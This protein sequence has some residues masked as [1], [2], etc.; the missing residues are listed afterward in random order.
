MHITSLGQDFFKFDA[1]SHQLKGERTG[2]R[3]RLG[4][5]VNVVVAGVNLDEK[6]IDFELLGLQSKKTQHPSFEPAKKSA[7]KDKKYKKDHK[8]KKMK[9]KDKLKAKSKTHKKGHK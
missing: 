1:T 5:E 3:Y 8:H 7:K 2:K 9:R 4:D 6:K